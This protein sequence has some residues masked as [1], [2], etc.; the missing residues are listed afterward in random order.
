MKF[1]VTALALSVGIFTTA[2]AI[3]QS[4]VDG[5]WTLQAKSAVVVSPGAAGSGEPWITPDKAQNARLAPEILLANLATVP[6]EFDKSAKSGNELQLPNPD[7][8]FS[9][10]RVLESPI[11]EP[12]LAAEFPEIKTYVGQGLDD[13]A[14]TVRLDWT[15]QGFHAS[16]L[17]PKAEHSLRCRR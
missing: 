15:P 10:F 7:G 1:F 8:G 12:A 14:A 16:V 4:S 9:R 3:A 5:A 2:S 13:P 11:M 17:T 6:A